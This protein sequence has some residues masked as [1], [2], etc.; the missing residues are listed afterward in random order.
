[1]F[2]NLEKNK[3]FPA[4]SDNMLQFFLHFI[5]IFKSSLNFPEFLCMMAGSSV[6]ILEFMLL[7]QDFVMHHI[8]Q[9]LFMAFKN[10][11]H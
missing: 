2:C 10:P 5:K 11:A 6:I 4:F 1:M 9:K 7:M 8:I 3:S